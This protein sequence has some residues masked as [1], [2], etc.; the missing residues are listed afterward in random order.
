MQTTAQFSDGNQLQQ[1]LAAEVENL[2]VRAVEIERALAALPAS[3]V[4]G[5]AQARQANVNWLGHLREQYTADVCR[6]T[7]EINRQF[8]ITDE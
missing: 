1:A 5:L 4:V 3:E 6:E 8:P 7:L 2:K